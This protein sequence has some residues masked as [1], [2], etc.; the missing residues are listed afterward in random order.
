AGLEAV[1]AGVAAAVGAQPGVGGGGPESPRPYSPDGD[2][3]RPPRVVLG[4]AGGC[5]PAQ[6]R[7]DPGP[8]RTPEAAQEQGALGGGTAIAGDEAQVVAGGGGGSLEV[9]PRRRRLRFE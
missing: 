6:G 2:V 9:L 7:I 1:G 4:V 3:D 5:G 8:A